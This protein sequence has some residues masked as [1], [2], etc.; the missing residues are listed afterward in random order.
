MVYRL[1]VHAPTKY[2]TLFP[3]MKI[4]GLSEC[5]IEKNLK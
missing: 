5:V 2:E 3:D 4:A 1:S